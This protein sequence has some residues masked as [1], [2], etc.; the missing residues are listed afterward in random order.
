MTYKLASHLGIHPRKMPTS[1]AGPVPGAFD[2]PVL[3]QLGSP[4]QLGILGDPPVQVCGASHRHSTSSA[5]VSLDLIGL[6]AN[7]RRCNGLTFVG[8]PG[9]E[10]TD[11][12]K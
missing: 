1:S 3:T 2:T 8:R 9:M 4:F 11:E 5:A 7:E 10:G 12:S 6:L